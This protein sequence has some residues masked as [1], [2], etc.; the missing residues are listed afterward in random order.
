[1]A[2]EESPVS[3]DEK[4]KAPSQEGGV[5]NTVPRSGK[6]R[7]VFGMLLGIADILGWLVIY[8]GL[9]VITGSY[10]VITIHAVL[11]PL[12]VLML[13]IALV[14]G[15]GYRTDFISLQYSSEHLIACLMA[16]PVA[17]FLLYVVTSFGPAPTSSRAIFSLSLFAFSLTSLVFRRF[18]YL[19]TQKSRSMG[20]FL[21]I[22][23]ERIGPV[24]HRD[25]MNSANTQEIRYMA[26]GASLVGR[27]VAGT[28]TPVPLVEAAHLLPHVNQYTVS[29][30]DGIIV[31][32]DLAILDPGVVQRLGVINFTEIP[33]Y[34]MESF[35]DSHWYRI[36]LELIGPGWPLEADFVLVQHSVYSSIK[37]LIDFLVALTALIALS[38]LFFLVAIAI[39]MLDGAPVIFSQQRTGIHR[40]PFT[41]HKFR[42]MK[43]GS[44][45]GDCY[46]QAGDARVTQFG[47]FLRKTR[48]DELPQLWNVLRGDMS[49]IGP[50]AEWVRLVEEYQEKIPYY[51]FRHL[52]RP[53]ITGWAQVNYP[54]GASLDDTLQ[55]LSFDLYYIR[56]FSLKLDAA[57]LL[58]TLHV[59]FFGKGR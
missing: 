1:M 45:R 57:V 3:D 33:V 30:Y 32:A 31:A 42:S 8:Y 55:K 14:R 9:S 54:Y 51:H 59:I 52:V 15:Y 43:V 40:E 26:A 21:V 38:P 35:Y 7:W 12:F 29:N 37:R 19:S 2:S 18:F 39:W 4:K 24:F 36:P 41:L 56:N 50:R 5:R 44:D 28:G 53:G 13:V 34:S 16:Y 47:M 25:Y 22:V 20:K 23:D 11:V 10:N 17:A 58:K 46:T 49:M 27:P 6:K 48:I